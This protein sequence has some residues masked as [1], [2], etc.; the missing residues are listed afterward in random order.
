MKLKQLLT[1]I[2]YR[3]EQVPDVDIT[4]LVYDSRKAVPGC[5]FVC[6]R[7]ANADGHK[8]AK[9]AAEKGAAVIIA[10]EPVEAPVPVILTDNTRL[11]LACLSAEFFGHP[12]EQMHVIGITGTKGKTTT[13]FMMRSILEAAGHKT[14][15][16]GTIGVLYGDTLVQTDN[17]TPENYEVQKFMRQMVDAGCEYCVMEVSSIGLKDHRVAGFTFELGLFT[18]FSEDHIGGAEHKD[19]ADTW[20]AK[21]CCSACAAP[22]S[23]ISMTRIIP[24]SSKIIRAILLPTAT[25]NRP[26]LLRMGKNSLPHRGSSACAS[27]S[28]AS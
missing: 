2:K 27:P 16:I 20:R 3:A 1:A 5:A 26:I 21:A 11:A 6:L 14:G 7:G 9:M 10:E 18:N 22:A 12:A 19:M 8:Y 15:V 28:Q 4:D 25:I 17:T 23:S 13:A 24:A